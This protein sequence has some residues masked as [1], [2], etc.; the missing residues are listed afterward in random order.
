MAS[1]GACAKVF[2]ITELLEKVLL[3]LPNKDLLLAQRVNQSFYHTIS[4]SPALQQKLFYTAKDT[5]SADEL[6]TINPLLHRFFK[7][8]RLECCSISF[9][10]KAHASEVRAEFMN[11]AHCKAGLREMKTGS[12]KNMLVASPPCAV[13]IVAKCGNTRVIPNARMDELLNWHVGLCG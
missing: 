4:E 2:A 6:P 3:Q 10:R 13:E 1:N 11:D 5:H 7:Y 9:A 8:R 12:W